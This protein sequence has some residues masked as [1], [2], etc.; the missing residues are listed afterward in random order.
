[1]ER[2]GQ[3]PDK[4]EQRKGEDDGEKG[5]RGRP[6]KNGVSSGGVAQFIRGLQ[7]ALVEEQKRHHGHHQRAHHKERRPSMCQN[8]AKRSMPDPIIGTYQMISSNKYE[9]YLRQNGCG[10]LSLNMVMRARIQLIIGK[11]PDDRW[12]IGWETAIK[13]KSVTGYSTCTPKLTQN[14]FVEG[15]EKP[16]LLDDWDQ[17]LVVSCLARGSDGRNLTVTQLAEKD[18]KYHLDGTVTYAVDKLDKDLLVVTYLLFGA[19]EEHKVAATRTFRRIPGPR[20]RESIQQMRRHSV[21]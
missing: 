18:Q 9:D 6:R 10:P 11:D 2:I 4:E 21:V 14:R 5:G 13:A 20:R 7:N 1:M 17:R 12:R 19:A 3:V 15:E 16:E 8:L